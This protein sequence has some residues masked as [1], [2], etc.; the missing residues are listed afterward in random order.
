MQSDSRTALA[1]VCRRV[2]HP[3]IRILVRFGISAGEFKAIVDSVYAH[4][5]SE[6]LE[7][8]GERVT[9][10]K[11]AVVT[12][13]NRAFLP[14][15]LK[16]PRNIFQPRSAVQLH[17]AARVLSGWYDDAKFRDRSGSPATLPIEGTSG[18]TFRRLCE[19]YS[20]SV[21]YQ[22]LLSEL[23]RLGAVRRIGRDK[24]RALRKMPVADDPNLDSLAAMSEL[25][26]DLLATLDYNLSVG[27]GQGLPVEHCIVLVDA[28][29]VPKLRRQVVRRT[30]R[31]IG[32]TKTYLESHRIADGRKAVL[33]PVEL[34]VAMFAIWRRSIPANAKITPGESDR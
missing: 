19:L 15:I 12:G 17:R 3:L 33:R 25:A 4:A 13:I 28:E 5:G 11:L 8:N 27:A 22:T 6:Y 20:G 34:G 24:V 23:E 31:A 14:A 18:A 7:T 21:Y 32:N 16:A 1:L 10:S 2:L 9:F 26:G 29:T 30:E